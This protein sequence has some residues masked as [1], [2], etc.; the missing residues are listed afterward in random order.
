MVLRDFEA[1]CNIQDKISEDYNNKAKWWR[2]AIMNTAS[3][4]YFSSDRTIADYNEKIWH[5][6]AI[7]I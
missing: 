1:Y 2:M 4:G 6:K 7:K 5:L 3:S